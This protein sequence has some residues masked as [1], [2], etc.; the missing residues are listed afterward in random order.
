MPLKNL[1]LFKII[2]AQEH[3]IVGST[4]K[5]LSQ[6]Q[7]RIRILSYLYNNEE[8]ANQHNIQFH[9]IVGHTQ[10]ASRFKVILDELCQLERIAPVDISYVPKGRIIYKITMKDKKTIEIIR[11]PLIKDF[12]GLAGQEI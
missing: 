2:S 4:Q 10:E 12:L 7:I 3:I 8:G 9:A 5:N 1:I 6:Q 11:N